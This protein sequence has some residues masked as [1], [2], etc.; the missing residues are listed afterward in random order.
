MKQIAI[1]A[2]AMLLVGAVVGAAGAWQWR[3]GEVDDAFNDG[4]AYQSSLEDEA[5]SS[6]A[7]LHVEMS[8]TSIDHSSTVASDGSVSTTT[9]N[10]VTLYINNTDET[11][12]AEDLKIT[13]YNPVTDTEGLH[14]NLETSDTDIYLTTSAGVT[15]RL[16]RNGDYTDGIEIPD[17]EPESTIEITVYFELEDAVAGT[18]QDGQTYDCSLYVYQSSAGYSDVVDYTIST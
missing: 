4:M 5:V 1:I 13:L 10:S 11:R 3:Q 16:F 8:D 14:D 15:S 9:A 12:D 2:V 18:F 6:V 17:L 7:S